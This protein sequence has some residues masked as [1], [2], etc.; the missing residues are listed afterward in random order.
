MN[1]EILTKVQKPKQYRKLISIISFL[2][3]VII[4]G[5][6][7]EFSLSTLIRNFDNFINIIIEM[8][9]PVNNIVELQEYF[10]Y[11]SEIW[12]ELI[13]TIQMAII[14]TVMGVLLS[15]P[16][17]L[18]ASVNISNKYLSIIIKFLLSLTRTLPVLIYAM[19]LAYIFGLGELPGVI[20][21]IIFT[22]GIATKMLYE[23]IERIDM[24]AYEAATASGVS[25]YNAFNLTIKPEIMPAFYSISLYMFEINIKS[26]AILGYVGAGGIGQQLKDTISLTQYSKAGLI[27][28]YTII[29][30]I[31]IDLITQYIRKELI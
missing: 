21:I 20:A 23:I 26:A 4:A 19:I 9:P 8:L 11:S 14:G 7:T 1:D 15:F 22:F 6:I 5:I 31:I 12:P 27:I 29:V 30:V 10:A 28:L 13:I 24:G 16:V 25:S 2:I 17:A 18:I 3:V